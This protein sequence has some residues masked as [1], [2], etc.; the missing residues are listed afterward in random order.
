MQDA[1]L[2]MSGGNQSLYS[3][4]LKAGIISQTKLPTDTPPSSGLPVRGG[5]GRT[6][7][8]RWYFKENDKPVR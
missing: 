7:S 8:E 1:M 2:L 4:L 6:H 3:G 5:F